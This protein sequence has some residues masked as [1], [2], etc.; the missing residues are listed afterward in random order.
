[1]DIYLI[2]SNTNQ[3]DCFNLVIGYKL[4]E[5]EAKKAIESL[6]ESYNKAEALYSEISIAR[7]KFNKENPSP[8][9]PKFISQPKWPSGIRQSDITQEMK[10]ER[11]FVKE[12]NDVMLKK[13]SNLYGL[14][15]VK[16]TKHLMPVIEPMMKES[17]FEKWFTVG[18]R[19]I[20]CSADG[21]VKGEEYI[22]EICEELK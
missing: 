20:S 3:Y 12:Q 16:Q 2:S 21:L 1:M 4:T 6:K 10:D 11:E 13:Y 8:E 17:W 18:D 7:E 14:W 15:Q 5:G 9:Y 19:F 22:Y